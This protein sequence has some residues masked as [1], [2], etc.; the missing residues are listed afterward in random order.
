MSAFIPGILPGIDRQI[1]IT[2]S[3]DIFIPFSLA[4]AAIS[5]Q[6]SGNAGNRFFRAVICLKGSNVASDSSDGNSSFGD[7]FWGF[8]KLVNIAWE[9]W[10]SEGC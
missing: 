9:N 7:I 5:S 3:L 1:R 10:F 4:S 8:S 6:P 2:L